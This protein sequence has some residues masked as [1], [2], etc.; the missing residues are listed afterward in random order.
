MLDRNANFMAER[1]S[2]MGVRVVSIQVLDDVPEEMVAAFRRALEREPAYILTTGGMGPGHDDRTR[3]CVAEATGLPLVLD[4][5]AR[6]MLEKSYR[7][8]FA[9]G[10]VEDPVLNEERLKMAR[11]P[12]GSVCY[13][14]PIGTAPAVS[15]RVGKTTFFLLPG[16]PEEM[17]RMFQLYV[18]PALLAEGTG[19]YRK[20]RH[21]E[22]PGSDES[23]LSRMLADLVRRHPGVQAKARPH[24]SGTDAGLR[25]TLFGEHS[26]EKELDRLLGDAEADLRARLG[27]EVGDPPRRAAGE[28]AA[29]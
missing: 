8:L 22:Y 27:L 11:V 10:L 12:K 19:S 23:A 1:L 4:E 25:I 15:L 13:E 7:R 5:R 20:A 9:K 29:E 17:Q 24:G 21:I 28:R 6:E 14:N 3:E 18:A 16:V 2:G 26:D